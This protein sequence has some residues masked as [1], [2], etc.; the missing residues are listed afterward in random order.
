MEAFDTRVTV[1]EIMPLLEEV[2]DR[3]RLVQKAKKNVF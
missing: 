3:M 1:A 2:Y